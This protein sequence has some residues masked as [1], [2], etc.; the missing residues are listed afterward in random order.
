MKGGAFF[1]SQSVD[2]AMP[3]D[4]VR[5]PGV[6]AIAVF[7]ARLI[8]PAI[9][10]SRIGQISRAL[11]AIR[12]FLVQPRGKSN[13]GH[14]PSSIS[15]RLPEDGIDPG[16]CRNLRY[17][18]LGARPRNRQ[19]KPRNRQGNPERSRLRRTEFPE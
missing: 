4:G 10:V 5:R 15:R 11:Y 3:M 1:Q 12:A 7:A 14:E 13:N 19:A 8:N 18:K 9:T 17:M 2:E 16:S 6:A